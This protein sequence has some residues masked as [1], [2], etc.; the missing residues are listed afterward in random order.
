MMTGQMCWLAGFGTNGTKILHVRTAPNQPW[1]SYQL[2]PGAV[3]DYVVPG[4]S[5]G[6]AT[7]QK[8]FREGWTLIS[9][10]EAQATAVVAVSS[11]A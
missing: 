11:A 3:P 6:W 10:A 9:T 4:G 2:F 1:Q 8:L 7:Y 5:K